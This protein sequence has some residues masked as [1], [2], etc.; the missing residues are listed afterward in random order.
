M[1]QWQRIIAVCA[2]SIG[3][4][5]LVS[6][7]PALAADAAKDVVLTGDAKCTR[8]HD[9]ADGP[10]LLAIGKTRH[11]VRADSRTPT[12]TSCHGESEKHLGHKGS[13]KPPKPDRTFGKNSATSAED[14]SAACMT[15]HKND[16]KRQHWTGSKHAGQDLACSSCHQVHTAQDKVRGR[17]TQTEVC[18]TCHKEQR[19]QANRISH[20]P[21]NEGKVICSDCHNTHG[22]TGPTLLIKN[23]LNATCYT[24]HAEKRGPLLW[25]HAPVTDDCGSCHTPHGSTNTPLLKARIPFLCQECHVNEHASSLVLSGSVL[26][27]G[28]VATTLGQQQPGDIGAGL[29]AFTNGRSCL[30][31]HVQVHGSNH[32]AGSKF[33]R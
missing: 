5:L 9:E 21:I 29:S 30:N 4:G 3:L 18:Y 7:T 15:C 8:C 1:K 28:A 2:A 27:G 22:S 20:H 16:P 19:A 13:D 14:R 25:E 17:T 26:S 23:T 32:P 33:N 6:A 24:C 10:Q 12:C 31:C 11:G